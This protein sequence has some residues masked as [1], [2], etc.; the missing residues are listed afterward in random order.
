[1][2]QWLNRHDGLYADYAPLVCCE[3]DPPHAWLLHDLP[4]VMR[5]RFLSNGI[6][7]K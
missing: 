7:S 6:Y 3:F 4:V 2:H 1:M 5:G